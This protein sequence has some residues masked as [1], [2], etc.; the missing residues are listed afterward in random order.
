MKLNTLTEEE[1]KVILEKGTEAPF[2][3]EYEN[4]TGEGTYVCR[5]C[6]APLYKSEDKFDAHCGW[7]SFDSEIPGAV[8][9]TLDKD[10]V[11]VEITCVNCGAHLG[12][13]FEGEG[14]TPKN[15]RYCVNSI[16]MKFVPK[17]GESLIQ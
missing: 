6:D 17:A 9:R 12:H 16:S 1:K 5:Q 3:G 15:I 10:G 13:V 14:L 7:P 2:S 4:F 11:R 8:K